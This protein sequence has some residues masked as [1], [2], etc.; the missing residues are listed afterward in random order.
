MWGEEKNGL[1]ITI[2]IS[3]KS[4]LVTALIV[5]LDTNQTATTS[6]TELN[7]CVF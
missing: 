6:V 5:Q 2:L 7:L 3:L 1:E 4:P